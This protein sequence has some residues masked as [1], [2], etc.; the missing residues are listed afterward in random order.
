MV[1]LRK[2][3]VLSELMTVGWVGV[4]CTLLGGGTVDRLGWGCV[5]F[6]VLFLSL[7]RGKFGL[8]FC[9]GSFVF[10]LVYFM[11]HFFLFNTFR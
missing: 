8:E 6:F 11:L 4:T 3:V 5:I 1:G 7:A 9:L 10:F 2:R